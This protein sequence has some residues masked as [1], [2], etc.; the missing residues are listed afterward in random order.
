[1]QI[2]SERTKAI[3]SL[4]TERLVVTERSE[5]VPVPV[6]KTILQLQIKMINLNYTEGGGY[7]RS[8]RVTRAPFGQSLGRQLAGINGACNGKGQALLV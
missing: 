4:D 2:C 5:V 3:R 6:I 7:N 8:I 1:M